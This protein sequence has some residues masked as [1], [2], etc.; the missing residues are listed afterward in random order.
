MNRELENEYRQKRE[1]AQRLAR[2]AREDAMRREPRLRNIETRR[3]QAMSQAYADGEGGYA[4]IKRRFLL[5]SAELDAEEAEI[6]DSIGVDKSDFLPKYSCPLCNDTG[7]TGDVMK[8]RCACSIAREN[9][10]RF[11]TSNISADMT[12]DVFDLNV[13]PE[14]EQRDYMRKLKKA[15]MKYSD[16]FPDTG[17]R[18]I[19]L[20]GLAGLGKSYL[21][22]CIAHR[23][24]KRG[25]TVVKV[26]AYS[27]INRIL[28]GIRANTDADREFINCDLLLIDDLGSEAAMKNITK[29]Y[30][31]LII[32]E[33]DA[34]NKHTV[35]ATNLSQ[36]QLMSTYS[37][38]LFS[39]LANQRDCSMYE[40][41]GADVRQNRK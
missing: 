25:Y 36:A 6:L 2:A 9:E 26:T 3:R 22:N 14:G 31:F 8:R 11:A 17:K 20:F 35:I 1:R 21:L 24:L 10:L 32:N 33:R 18:N 39:R 15:L 23:V 41:K 28:E 37:E 27:L 16:E 30:I 5:I 12:F 40:L 4:E 29:E 13:F 34:L 19:L 38:R 7:Y